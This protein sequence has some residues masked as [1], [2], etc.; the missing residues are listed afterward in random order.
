M[1]NKSILKKCKTFLKTFKKT[2]DL[3]KLILYNVKCKVA[4][5]LST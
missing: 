2:I 1:I 4:R 5:E 3:L